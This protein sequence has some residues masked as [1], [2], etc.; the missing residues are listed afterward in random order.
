MVRF[1]SPAPDDFVLMFRSQINREEFPSGQRGQTVNLLAP[2]SVVRIHPPPPNRP[3]TSDRPAI[4]FCRT[5]SRRGARRARRADAPFPARR[6]G[7]A[8]VAGEDLIKKGRCPCRAAGQG[9]FVRMQGHGAAQRGIKLCCGP[10]RPGPFGKTGPEKSGQPPG[11]EKTGRRAAGGKRAFCIETA[12]GHL[13]Q[14]AGER[15]AL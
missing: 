8:G 5:G 13:A 12:S 6:L 9:P 4:S 11:A 14:S 3:V 15:A 1:R 10:G 2:P 7:R